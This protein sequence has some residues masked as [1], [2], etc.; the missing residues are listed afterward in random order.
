MKIKK[1]IYLLIVILLVGCHKIK[2]EITPKETIE[3]EVSIPEIIKYN[4]KIEYTIDNTTNFIPT[5]KMESR[6]ND[7][8][9]ESNINKHEVHITNATN[10]ED[11]A[12]IY[13]SIYTDSNTTYELSFEVVGYANIEVE[14]YDNN[15]HLLL[16]E[17]LI[18]NNEIINLK[19]KSINQSFENTLKMMVG[20]N[21]KDFIIKDIQIKSNHPNAVSI[22]QVGYNINEEKQAIFSFYAGNYFN[23]INKETN[24][25]VYSGNILNKRM[26]NGAKDIYGYGDFSTYNEPGSY[27]IETEFNHISE[28]F[29]IKDD[30]YKNLIEDSLKMISHQRCGYDLS[31]ENFLD[32]AHEGC[33]KDEVISYDYGHKF[34][35]SGGWHDAGDYGRYTNTLAKTL[36]ELMLSYILSNNTISDN[37][38]VDE[39]NNGI[40]D[41]LDEIKVGLE[42][43]IN[44]Q[45][46]DGSMHHKV[47]PQNFPGNILPEDDKE[48][49]YA[50]SIETS[51]TAYGAG[52]LMLGSQLFEKIDQDYSKLI[53][54]RAILAYDFITNNS[55]IISHNPEGF[56]SGIYRDSEDITERYFMNMAFYYV[57]EDKVYLDE[58][59]NISTNNIFNKFNVTYASPSGYGSFLYLL[60]NENTMHNYT[61][62]NQLI[63]EANDIYYLYGLDPFGTSLGEAYY[64]GSNNKLSENSVIMMM[65]NYI[66]NDNLYYQASMD[67]LHYLLGRNALNKS[68]IS[69]YGNDFP[70]NIHHRIA[71]I[72]NN[73]IKGALVGG[74]NAFL[75]DNI[76]VSDTIVPPAKSYIDDHRS[77]STNEVA[78]YY[79]STLVLLLTML[80]I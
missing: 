20:N 38:G 54:D 47:I 50:M 13:H 46:N 61:L 59:I 53:K 15:Q 77:Y 34:M 23:L 30:V 51:A 56:G 24:E 27:Y 72:K 3:P 22:N 44:V 33:H 40:S 31:E 41:L 10:K 4:E 66:N 69:G 60:K 76:Q 1:F 29:V 52:L 16:D 21:E 74:P 70:K 78:I 11:L 80:D 8:Y 32:F 62:S 57:T 12:L 19:F 28:V 18:I 75:E 39:S 48:Q 63:K 79:N 37:I 64:W 25:I 73:Y 45:L 67:S 58:A 26:S 9:I 55:L 5:Y 43:L 71:I 36:M 6:N 68:F 2:G 17:S 35:M 65:A 42:Y 7:A 49:E 14:I